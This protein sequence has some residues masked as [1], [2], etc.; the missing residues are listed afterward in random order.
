MKDWLKVQIN[1][2]GKL[3]VGV[4][5]VG[6]AWGTLTTQLL[7]NRS[8][9]IGIQLRVDVCATQA[10]VAAVVTSVEKFGEAITHRVERLEGFHFQPARP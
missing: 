7:A 3:I 1:G 9:L 6:V 2:N 8:S 5:A 10:S 4:L